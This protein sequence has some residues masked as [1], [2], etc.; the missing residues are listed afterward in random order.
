MMESKF[1]LYPF[2]PFSFTIYFI[3]KKKKTLNKIISLNIHSTKVYEHNY[4]V[5]LERMKIYSS[6]PNY[7]N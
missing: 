7:W 6:R 5:A 1:P 4:P 3:E 2:A